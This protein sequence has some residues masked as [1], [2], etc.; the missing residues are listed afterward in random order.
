[1]QVQTDKQSVDQDAELA[2][3]NITNEVVECR[4]NVDAALKKV[5]QSELQLRQAQQ[6]YNLAETSFKAGTITNLDLLDSSTSLSESELAVMKSH[7]DYT[8]NLLKL[9][10]A[11]GERIY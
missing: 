10:I 3:R 9:K 8:V 7:I 11:L 1:M 4:A 2:R 6:A 5:S